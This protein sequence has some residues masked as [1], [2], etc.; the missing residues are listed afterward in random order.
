MANYA[1]MSLL[2]KLSFIQCNWG[3][4]VAHSKAMIMGYKSFMIEVGPYGNTMDYAYKRHSILVTNS[5]WFKNVWALVSYCNVSLNFDEDYQLKPIR[6]GNKPLMS[7]FLRYEDFGIDDVL[8][9]NIMRMHKKVIHVSD[10]VLSDGRTIK[11]EMFLNLPGNSC[12]H[13]FTNSHISAPHLQIYPYGK[14]HSTK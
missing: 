5:T 13:K 8:S 11:L 9:L 7:K 6:R 14:W 3:F 4:D 1:L 2:L 10:I 12:V